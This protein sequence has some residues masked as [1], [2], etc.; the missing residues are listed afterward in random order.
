MCHSMPLAWA[1]SSRSDSEPWEPSVPWPSSL[2]ASPATLLPLPGQDE[3]AAA[4]ALTLTISTAQN[5][6]TAGIHMVYSLCV[7]SD[8]ICQVPLASHPHPCTHCPVSFAFVHGHLTYHG[9]TC[10][11]IAPFPQHY[12]KVQK[13][14]DPDVFTACTPRI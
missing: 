6:P 13:G 1:S 4:L 9:F 10:L 5:P 12:I 7:C 2:S 8:A 14:R 3:R 11:L